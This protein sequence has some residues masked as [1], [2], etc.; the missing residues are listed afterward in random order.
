[1]AFSVNDCKKISISII[2]SNLNGEQTFKMISEITK[3]QGF[4][5]SVKRTLF[6][7]NFVVLH[8]QTLKEF[9]IESG[10]SESDAAGEVD[11]MK[12]YSETF[13]ESLNNS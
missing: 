7:N 2:K 3:A 8:L 13:V 5:S 6:Y 1:M 9:Y 12:S 10:L 4:V 11:E